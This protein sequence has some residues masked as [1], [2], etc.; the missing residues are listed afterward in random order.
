VLPKHIVV[1]VVFPQ[2]DVV[3]VDPPLL[4]TVLQQ[5][6]YLIADFNHLGI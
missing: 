1:E 3:H 4:P 5:T 6:D 2:L